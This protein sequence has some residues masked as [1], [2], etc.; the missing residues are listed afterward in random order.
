MHFTKYITL[1]L[2][3][4]SV[5]A[6]TGFFLVFIIFFLIPAV[7]AANDLA[8]TQPSVNETS[9][10]EMRDFYVYGI[11]PNSPLATPGDVMIRLFPAAS[12]TGTVCTGLPLRQIQSHVDPVSGT[13]NRSCLDFSFVNGVTVGG[14]YVPDIVINPDGS[15]FTDPNN[16]VVVTDRYYAGL[17]LGGV[18]QTYNTTYKDS[19]GTTLQNLTAG[20]YTILVTGLSGTLNGENITE[21]I[22]FG[23]TNTALGTNRPPDNKN[24]RI[25][26]AIQHN[27]RTYFDAFPGYFSDGGSNWS[28]FVFRAYPNNGIEVVNDLSGTVLD[29]IAVAN[30][31]MFLYN[32]NSAST[33]LLG[34]TGPDP[35]VQPSGF[36]EYDIPLLQQRGTLFKIRRHE[37]NLPE[38]CVCDHTLYRREPAR[39]HPGRGPLYPPFELREPL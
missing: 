28:N 32:I 34:R 18:T 13:T 37:R 29:T 7:H 36:A 5:K 27:L 9:F 19:S 21:N 20:D 12:C 11:F 24:A 31:T 16:K 30:N 25:S 1:Y 23:I 26:Y 6:S 22:T 3:R 2:N 33:D 35:E 39:P 10:A 8:I 14:G 17:V 4:I 38:H 15:G